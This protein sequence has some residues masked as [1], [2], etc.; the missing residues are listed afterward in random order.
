MRRR[1]FITL[2]GG[3]AIS[4]PLAARAQQAKLSVIGVLEQGSPQALLAAFRQGLSENG[5]VEGRNVAIEYCWAEDQFDRLPALA[6]DLVRRQV[7]VIYAPGIRAALAAK[8]ATNDSDHLRHQRRPGPSRSRRQSEPTGRQPHGREPLGRG[9]RSEAAGAGARG[10]ARGDPHWPAPQ[11]DQSA[12]RGIPQRPAGGRA[13]PRA[14]APYPLCEHRTRLRCR[15][16]NLGASASGGL[17]IGLDVFLSSRREQ[18]AAL[19]L[20]GLGWT[21][22]TEAIVLVYL[23]AYSLDL[24]P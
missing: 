24:N 17:I 11:P 3:A 15:L 6:A 1:D 21:D 22:G 2:L 14:A 13:H 7:T 5:Y 12:D 19:A 23:P 8:A 20:A 18:L 9:D 16:R 10:R 4:W